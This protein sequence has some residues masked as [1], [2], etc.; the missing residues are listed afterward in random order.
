MKTF[1][2]KYLKIARIFIEQYKKDSNIIGITLNG[3]VSRGTGDEYS[4]IDIHFYVKDKEKSK[5]PPKIKGIGNDIGINGVWF[6][7]YIK[8]IDKYLKKEINIAEKWDLKHCKILFDRHDKV[9]QLIK[10][11]TV[12]TELEKEDI[13]EDYGFGSAWC[14]Q[15]ANI[16][17]HRGDLKN[18]H[19]LILKSLD[20]FVN[21]YFY[22]NK[23]LIPHFKWKYHYFK[24]LKMPNKKIKDFI[25]EML[26]IKNYS[27]KEAKNKI[28]KIKE[29]LNRELKRKE[30]PT[31]KQSTKALDNFLISVLL[32]GS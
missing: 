4:E 11:K 6:D 30:N 18:A 25:F 17:L 20:F 15:L 16:S 31:Y 12:L 22:L 3:G 24:E 8:E 9:K 13:E 29:V 7:I 1:Q 26:K 14:L 10:N 27:K 28:K 5:L 23:K 2:K 21:Y 32:K 19:L